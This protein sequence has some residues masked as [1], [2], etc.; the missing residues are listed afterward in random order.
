MAKFRGDQE[1]LHTVTHHI[2]DRQTW[3]DVCP[4][5]IVSYKYHCR[6]KGD[7]LPSNA[8]VVCFHGNPRPHEM[9]GNHWTMEHWR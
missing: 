6:P 7:K 5:Q 3:A 9:P 4:K 1:W 8:R 2:P